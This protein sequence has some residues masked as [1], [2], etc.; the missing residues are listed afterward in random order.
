MTHPSINRA[1]H[2]VT[3]LIETNV[4]PLSQATTIRQP[5]RGQVVEANLPR[6]RFFCPQEPC[7]WDVYFVDSS[8]QKQHAVKSLCTGP[9]RYKDV[10]ISQLSLISNCK[11]CEIHALQQPAKIKNILMLLQHKHLQYVT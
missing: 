1:R 3:T 10:P 7:P 2:R 9:V 11:V 6:P 8:V 4:L 5:T